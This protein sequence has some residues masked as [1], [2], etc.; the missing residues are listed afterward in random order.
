[1]ICF[2]GRSFPR[3]SHPI[4]TIADDGR[5]LHQVVRFDGRHHQEPESPLATIVRSQRHI[6]KV[7][8]QSFLQG[9]C[10]VQVTELFAVMVS[11]SYRRPI[12]TMTFSVSSSFRMF[13]TLHIAFIAFNAVHPFPPVYIDAIRDARDAHVAEIWCDYASQGTLVGRYQ[14]SQEQESVELRFV[15]LLRLSHWLFRYRNAG[16]AHCGSWRR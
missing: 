16:S 9:R 6:A 5:T 11:M 13:F 7:H 8:P 14:Q 4:D 12:K 15:R 1:M 2:E 10:D 3:N